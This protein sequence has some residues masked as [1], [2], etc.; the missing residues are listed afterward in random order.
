MAA[1]AQTIAAIKKLKITPGPLTVAATVPG[2]MK[3]PVPIT[4]PIPSAIKSLAR[5]DF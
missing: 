2:K 1:V 5:N 4:A 3:I